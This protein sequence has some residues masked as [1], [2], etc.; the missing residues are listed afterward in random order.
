VAE[1]AWPLLLKLHGDYQEVALRNTTEELQQQDERQRRT[2]IGLCGQLGLIVVGYSGR[3]ESVMEALAE[4]VD[5]GGFPTGLFWMRRPGTQLLDSVTELLKRA[6]A[7]GIETAIVEESTFDELA[8]ELARNTELPQ[9]LSDHLD[10]HTERPV[11]VPVKLP[12]A[13]SADYPVLRC[14]AL[15]V[16]LPT[17]A[18]TF[19]LDRQCTV[20]E[21]RDKLA[22]HNLRRHTAF[23][24]QGNRLVAFGRDAD[25][26]QAGADLG[27]TVA[28]KVELDPLADSWALG[29]LVD[30]LAG[31]LVRG[32][33]LRR[34]HV[35]G[36]HALLATNPRPARPDDEA[37]RRMHEQVAALRTAYRTELTGVVPDINLAFAEGVYLRLEH[38]AERWWAVYEPF[39]WVD[40]PRDPFPEVERIAADWRRERWALRYNSVWAGIIDAWARIFTGD[41][42]TTVRSTRLDDRPGMAAEFHLAP[43]NGWS[44][45]AGQL[46]GDLVGGHA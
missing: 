35:R 36:I 22:Q 14:S 46:A 6:E 17:D 33:A 42:P 15:P 18:R 10:A 39:T 34:R 40:L 21:F 37:G 44:R 27:I 4:A 12:T 8:G 43:K 32:R 29:L 19:Q 5:A 31:S 26:L 9:A 3:D 23:S 11:V 16:Q 1:A 2:L 45:P 13:E 20:Q 30:A 25:Y 28:G 41:K 7:A 24:L 38:R